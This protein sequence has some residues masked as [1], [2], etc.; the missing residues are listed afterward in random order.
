MLRRSLIATLNRKIYQL[1]SGI[2]VQTKKTANH[3][4][5]FEEEGGIL[6]FTF[7]ESE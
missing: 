1:E 5:G 2:E 6:Y 7:F 3:S 4:V